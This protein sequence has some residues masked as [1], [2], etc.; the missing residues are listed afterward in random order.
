MGCIVRLS[1]LIKICCPRRR[2]RKPNPLTPRIVRWLYAILAAERDT[3]K[4]LVVYGDSIMSQLDDLKAAQSATNS[5]LDEA[6][7]AIALI[8]GRANPTDLTDAIATEQA[9]TAKAQAVVDAANG[10]LPA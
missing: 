3:Q 10:T 5:K 8:P 6:I 9:N 4:A 2:L 1:Q 7:A